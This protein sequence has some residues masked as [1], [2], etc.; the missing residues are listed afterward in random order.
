MLFCA[1]MHVCVYVSV[2]ALVSEIRGKADIRGKPKL[3]KMV[4]CT[5]VCVCVCIYFYIY[6]YIYT[7]THIYRHVQAQKDAQDVCQHVYVRMHAR[8][9]ARARTYV[10]KKPVSDLEYQAREMQ[11]IFFCVCMCV[12]MHACILGMRCEG[13]VLRR[14]YAPMN[15]CV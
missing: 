13:D 10:H 1:C 4:F 2:Q 12:S 15:V 14:M 11:K 8:L 5:C 7:H 6:I 3:N 9:C